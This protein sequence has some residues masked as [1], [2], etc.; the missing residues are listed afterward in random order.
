MSNRHRLCN[1]PNLVACPLRKQPTVSKSSSEVKYEVIACTTTK[2]IWIRKLLA[3]IGIV[4]YIRTRVTCDNISA[5]YLIVNPSHHDY[6][7]VHECVTDGDVIVHYV[8]TEF[9][10][11]DIFTKGLSS[12]QF[13]FL[14]FNLSIHSAHAQIEGV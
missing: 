7:F 6:H 1:E 10:L 5:T 9:E 12:S 14:M 13:P 11:A 4:L 3:D 2:T 8:P